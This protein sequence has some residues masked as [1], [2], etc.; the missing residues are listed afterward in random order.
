MSYNALADDPSHTFFQ[1]F[2]TANQK[3]MLRFQMSSKVSDTYVNLLPLLWRDVNQ[4]VNFSYSIHKDGYLPKELFD[5]FLF[6]D[7]LFRYKNT[8]WLSLYKHVLSMLS[9]SSL[10]VRTWRSG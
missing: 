2:K 6:L 4:D 10:M 9:S 1:G 7:R 5:I 3:F 8:E